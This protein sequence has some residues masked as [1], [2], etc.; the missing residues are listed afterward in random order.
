MV[1]VDKVELKPTLVVAGATKETVLKLGRLIQV[2]SAETVVIGIRDAAITA[3]EMNKGEVDLRM[4][5]TYRLSARTHLFIN[6]DSVY[7][8]EWS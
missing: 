8:P 5:D 4:G 6:V 7:A 3:S 1:W 2:L